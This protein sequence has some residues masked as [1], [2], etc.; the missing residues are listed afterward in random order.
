MPITQSRML[1][2]LAAA[3]DFEQGFNTIIE[4]GEQIRRKILLGEITPQAACEAYA[5]A[6]MPLMLLRYPY[7]SPVVIRLETVHFA[8]ERKRN[9][10]K[11]EKLRENR[12]AE[13]EG[14][15]RPVRGDGRQHGYIGGSTEMKERK[16]V[17]N[18]E[19][20]INAT[21]P[22]SGQILGRVEMPNQIPDGSDGQQV[23]ADTGLEFDYTP[24]T[25]SDA[26]K[27]AIEEEAN[28]A[29]EF[30]PL[31]GYAIAQSICVHTFAE[32]GET[33]A[34]CGKAMASGGHGD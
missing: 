33:C 30:M 1:S 18:I 12:L 13:V 21:A 24:G 15:S 27:A 25:L 9:D 22:R 19:P 34:D 26:Q 4:Q 32:S 7:E 2:L 6:T 31:P 20:S 17:L 8:R 5:K 14:K 29:K 10:R 23:Q 16:R 3:Q 28:T 11:A